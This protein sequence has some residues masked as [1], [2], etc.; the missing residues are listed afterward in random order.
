MEKIGTSEVYIVYFNHSPLSKKS[1]ALLRNVP[2]R[3][4]GVQGGRRPPEKCLE[5]LTL[6]DE[7]LQYL[8]GF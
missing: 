8:E 4:G 1:Y 7:L 5:F 2:D 3:E 6:K